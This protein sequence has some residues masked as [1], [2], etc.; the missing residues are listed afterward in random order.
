M[1]LASPWPCLDP[2]VNMSAVLV[3]IIVRNTVIISVVNMGDNRSNK[4]YHLPS[5]Q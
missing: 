1:Q 4:N 3:T 5:T 2:D